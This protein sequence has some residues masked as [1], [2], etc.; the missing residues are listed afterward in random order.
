MSS[1]RLMVGIALAGI[2][3][4][5]LPATAAVNIL[6]SFAGGAGDGEVPRGSLC[7]S[8]PTVYGMTSMGGAFGQGTIFRM[9]T[10]G[11]GYSVLHSFGG[12][13]DGQTPFR[14]LIISGTM[15]YGTT[16]NG[17]SASD[18][19]AGGTVFRMNTDGTGY[20]I[21][22]NFDGALGGGTNP[23]GALCLAGS[24]LYG[25]T[26][27]GYN[28]EG[29]PNNM[30]TVFRVNTD[31]TGFSDLHAFPVTDSSTN[32][33]DGMNG[34]GTLALSGS[35]LYGATS[36]GGAFGLGTI[37]RINTDGSGFGLVHSFAGGAGDGALPNSPIVSGATIYGM[38]SLGGSGGGAG[39]IYRMNTDGTGYSVLY[40]FA[41]DGLITGGTF[42]YEG[43]VILSG[44]RLYG[45]TTQ[46]GT[47]D[48]GTIF[49]MN[50][51]GT[52]YG[53]LHSF[54]AG[55]ADGSEP[56]DSLIPS[57]STL[58]GMT[59]SG[60]SAFKGT[61][62]SLVPGT[63]SVAGDLPGAV[64]GV[65]RAAPNPFRSAVSITGALSGQRSGLARV[66]VFDAAGRRV[67]STRAPVVDGRVGIQWSG[68]DDAGMRLP[69]GTYLVRFRLG[70]A[71]ATTSVVLV[72]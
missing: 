59:T 35:T 42:P 1:K 47:L 19:G 40:A 38:T 6:R 53:V 67:R 39:T 2:L 4:S 68:R 50:T 31:G 25:I 20:V 3:G 7:I 45:M 30:G 66:E 8:G 10:N 55:P 33:T 13:G 57:D 37:F 17:G 61:I 46:G 44:G 60:G 49:R 62:F 21:L 63:V 72:P 28:P 12:A 48:R 64:L 18:P 54:A 23:D 51:D 9:N 65:L 29:M 52:S 32:A 43:S 26:T 36:G 27:A 69:A 15:V 41:W 56:Y 34:H 24:T 11:S 16:Y 22:H 71:S 5:S 70:S 58:Y 14:S